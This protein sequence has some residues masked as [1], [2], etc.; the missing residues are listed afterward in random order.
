[1]RKRILS[2]FYI[3]PVTNHEIL[4]IAKQLPSKTSCYCD[5]LFVKIVK[6]FIFCIVDPLYFTFN[7][8]F[9]KGI[10][11]T[12]LKMANIF[13]IFKFGTKADIQNYRPISLLPVFS[14][15]LEKLM[16][17]YLSVFFNKYNVLNINQHGF[18]LNYSTS[19]VVA[20]ILNYVQLI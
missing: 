9:T 10:F 4:A 15:I 11:L 7:K 1:M 14:K 16:F 12:S 3:T 18:S 2:S 19:T 6:Y 20:D 17:F 5:G 8:S 13:F